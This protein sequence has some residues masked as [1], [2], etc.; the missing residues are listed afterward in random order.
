MAQRRTIKRAATPRPVDILPQMDWQDV[1]RDL[2]AK[3]NLAREEIRQAMAA[4][5]QA[6]RQLM[7]SD[8][9]ELLRVYCQDAE[10]FVGNAAAGLL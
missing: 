8:D 2:W 6:E 5:V 3:F 10:L 7:E 1:G 4:K 9:Q